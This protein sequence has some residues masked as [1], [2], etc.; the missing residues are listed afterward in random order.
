VDLGYRVGK[1]VQKGNGGIELLVSDFS[2]KSIKCTG[3][4][5]RLPQDG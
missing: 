4:S 1:N 5:L 3:E 2:L